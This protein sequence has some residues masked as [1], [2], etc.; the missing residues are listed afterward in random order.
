MPLYP[1][2]YVFS[3]AMI[4]CAMMMLFDVSEAIKEVIV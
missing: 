4:P 3:I 1:F 2:A